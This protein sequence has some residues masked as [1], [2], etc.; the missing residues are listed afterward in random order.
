[1]NEKELSNWGIKRPK[2]YVVFQTAD[3]EIISMK[4][5][6]NKSL[7]NNEF[8]TIMEEDGLLEPEEKNWEQNE[9]IGTLRIA[10]DHSSCVQLVERSIE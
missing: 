2:L 10:G 7:A 5:F 4:I 8:E 3:M 1:M 6:D 9:L